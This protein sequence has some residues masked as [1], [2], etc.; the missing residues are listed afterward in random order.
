MASPHTRRVGGSCAVEPVPRQVPSWPARAE[1]R[2]CAWPP[3][4]RGLPW[5]VAGPDRAACQFCPSRRAGGVP[6]A[7]GGDPGA[8]A[9][10]EPR[11]PAENGTWPDASPSGR[12]VYVGGA[13]GALWSASEDG[14][15]AVP[16][17]PLRG[18]PPTHARPR[19]LCG[20]VVLWS[21]I[22]LCPL[23]LSPD[24]T[25]LPRA[26]RPALRV[27][28]GASRFHGEEVSGV[29]GGHCSFSVNH[30]TSSRF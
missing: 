20:A 2:G 9:A 22:S 27:P 6:A 10:A 4:E 26:L 16:P 8:A 11:L 17:C 3:V 24:C 14:S 5:S 21:R 18:A 25:D 23:L 29:C 30:V 19:S 28:L 15:G 12:G 7:V 1:G 13:R